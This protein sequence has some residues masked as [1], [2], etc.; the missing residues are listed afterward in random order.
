M[1]APS[2][3]LYVAA[4]ELYDRGFNVIPLDCENRP[5]VEYR[6]SVRVDRVR[7][8]QLLDKAC[9]VGLVAGVENP[10]KPSVL[11]LLV[12][13][14]SGVLERSSG[15]R[16]LVESTASYRSGER[17]VALLLIP[18][19]VVSALRE[20]SSRVRSLGVSL[21][22]E[23][24]YPIPPTLGYE[25]AKPL[26]SVKSENYGIRVLSD[27]SAISALLREL[28]VVAESSLGEYVKSSEVLKK[29]LRELSEEELSRLE[30]LV[31]PVLRR[32]ECKLDVLKWI[33]GWL[34]RALVSPVSTTRLLK[35]LA[36]ES[37]SG[38][39]TED[40]LG[41]VTCE[42]RSAGVG[43]E[44]YGGD[45]EKALGVRV[46]DFEEY[47]SRCISL[48]WS[49]ERLREALISEIGEAGLNNLLEELE[50]VI[51]IASK[52]VVLAI[53]LGARLDSVRGLLEAREAR[54]L[55]E[56]LTRAAD[57]VV[58]SILNYF[59]YVKN[60][61]IG[62]TDLG[63]HCWDGK[64]YRE[65]R[66]LI[67]KLI[68]KHHNLL[69]LGDYGVRFTSLEK[70]VIRILEHRTR[71]QLKYESSSIAFE[72]CVFDWDTLTCKPHSPNRVVLHYIPHRLDVELLSTLLGV[73]SIPEDVV[74]KYAP[75]TLRAF[76]EWVSDKWILLFEILGFVLYPR[77]H[78]KAVLLVD[79]EGKEGD[80]GKSTYIRYLQLVLGGENYSTIPLQALVDPDKRFSASQIYKKLANFY[81]DLPESALSEVG[82]FKVLTGEDAITI[83]R[84]YK[85]PFTWLPYTKHIFSAN[86]P[87]RVVNP[88]T[89]FWKRWLV[90]EFIGGFKEPIREFEKT[91]VGEIPQTVA[92]GIAAFRSVLK[93]GSFSFEN[94]PE[95]AKHKWMSRSDTVY[96]FMEWLKSSSALVEY[97]GGV[98][99]VEDLYTYYTRYCSALDTAPESQA[100]FTKRLKELGYVVKK[101]SRISRLRGYVLVEEKLREAF[102]KLALE[103]GGGE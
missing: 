73:D 1:V 69:K 31:T 100:E 67:G 14:D 21:I 32:V 38:V 22:L 44:V 33:T 77:P 76:R 17:T 55:S 5:L 63:L 49:W 11:A 83:E 15:L 78:K 53:E 25:W 71:E 57:L 50:R 52:P 82:Q 20:W 75:K 39:S 18:R 68:E 72:N 48:E 36:Q 23:D 93:R 10:F 13:E 58:D 9:G 61:S 81:A 42:Y 34:S 54:R 74:E 98:V 35:R 26:T 103:E 89:A 2:L 51:G 90:V 19:E 95:D 46:S 43:V 40:I 94:T 70:E 65:C 85:E 97:P 59:R 96:A 29:T 12:V 41:L 62:D 64:S 47:T 60:F 27:P 102:Q 30:D 4:L 6:S 66:G 91:L 88:D 80:T 101:H 37:S 16:S 28:G 87:P 56:R 45:L 99:L 24:Y 8:V 7:L 86:I 92:I 3:D 79:A 84:K